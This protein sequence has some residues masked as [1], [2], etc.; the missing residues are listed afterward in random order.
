MRARVCF[1]LLAA[2]ALA[3][4][5][6]AGTVL[7]LQPAR[8]DAPLDVVIN[9]VAWMG[10]LASSYDEWI[11]LHNPTAEPIDL[12]G[13]TLSDGGDISIA[14]SGVIAAGGYFLLERTDDTTIADI[15]ADRIYV[16]TLSNSGERLVLRNAGGQ[17]VDTADGSGGWP[18]GNATARASMERIDPTAPDTPANWA[19]NDGLTC[20]GRDAAGN[21]IRGTPRTRN[22][23]YAIPGLYLAK[24]GPP[25]VS[26]G[27]T[28][29]CRLRLG[30]SGSLTATGVVLTDTLPPGLAFVAQA[31]VLPFS[32]PATSTLR[33]AV[34]DLPPGVLHT[35]TLT[36]H[37]AVNL[38]G[39]VTNVAT[40]TEQ[41]GRMETAVWS[42][43]VVPCVRL[44]ALEPVNYGG[45]GE[46]AALINLGASAVSLGGWRLNDDPGA[47]GVRFPLTATVALRQILWLA[48]NA[49]GFAPVWGFDADW[50]AA[51]V[52]RPTPLLEGAWP[53]FTDGGEAAYLFD[54]GGRLVDALAYGSG[55]AALGWSGPAAP[56][57][58]SGYSAGQVLY[59]K[60]DQRSG[61]PVPDTDTAADWAQDPLDPVDG[62]RLR[63]P[64][65]DLEALFFPAVATPTVPITLA[66]APDGAFELVSRTLAAARESIWIEGY[67]FES[68]ALYQVID[69][70]LRA[71][72]V[73]T[74]LLE[75]GPLGGV[76]KSELWIARAIDGHPN[77][78]VYFLH[79]ATVRYRYQ[80]AKFAVIDGRVALVSTENLNAGGMPSDPKD[81]GTLGHRGFVVVAESPA[82]VERLMAIVGYDL[83]VAHHSDLIPYG[84]A[85]FVL[86]DA[87]F[88][89]LPEPDWTTYAAPFSASLAT[90]A[91]HMTVLHA[92][93]NSLRSVDGL[94]GLVGRAGAGDAVWMMQLS[95]PY[96]WT[97][98]AGDVG[99]NPRLQ[100]LLAAARRGATVRVLLDDFYNS[101]LTAQNPTAC[102]V[103][104]R[105]AA[106]ERLDLLCHLASPAGLGIHAKVL[107]ARLGDERWVHLGSIN[108]SETASK[109]NREVALQFRSPAAFERMVAVFERDWARSHGPFDYRYILPVVMRNAIP[110]ASYPLI[111]EVL[112]NPS[113]MDEGREWIELYNPGAAVSL[114]NWT[115]GDAL[116]V[117]SYGD[118]RY[119]FPRGAQLVQGQVVVL[120]ACASQF[121]AAYGFNP[122]YEWMSCDPT[123][124]D[125]AAVGSWSGFGI[126]L[127]NAGDEVLLLDAAGQQV[128]S[129][130]WG[131]SARAGVV[132]YPLDPGDTFPSGA[133]LERAPAYTDR[134]DCAQDFRIR[135][136]PRPGE[137]WTP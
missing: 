42:A 26:A 37:A 2:V 6:F 11:E 13:W 40:A 109:V 25:A 124:P 111:S 20:N 96:T 113:G 122:A 70:R 53:G 27:L 76:S 107:L 127:G 43:P 1:R 102:R 73:V 129:A 126:A 133:S 8:A 15:P 81:N 77:G 132:P 79:G 74:V 68:A 83:D 86:D 66:V 32:R 34:G 47:G 108:G 130:A 105:I 52:A 101:D 85:P 35:I 45:S 128:D 41:A 63:Y 115:I 36:L 97:A 31:S 80:H 75:G 51:N 100:A 3:A 44:Y 14:L 71:G 110:P 30:N 78:A 131:G 49:D 46:V 94:L 54:D 28:L 114:A 12:A 120:A 103:L 89:P 16:G 64:G 72:V 69:D 17:I 4:I 88:T 95:E 67:T 21:P 56:Y 65:W 99:L 24:E 5:A 59:R 92:P 106:Q 18:A 93:E 135:Y 137:V 117:G 60:L 50:A 136:T 119:R 118:G 91:T 123:V 29:T 55:G 22:A 10:T 87:A 38:S 98:M 116:N 61:L 19:T 82:A 62:R 125:L 39:T 104:N 7:S 9:E 33:W 23:C 90:T 121:A 112:I 57:P 48:Q 134:N 58:Y 84:T